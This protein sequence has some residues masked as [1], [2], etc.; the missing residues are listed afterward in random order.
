MERLVLLAAVATFLAAGCARLGVVKGGQATAEAATGGTAAQVSADGCR[1]EPFTVPSPAMK[2]E[3]RALVLLPPA[4]D[5]EPARRF[6]V[7]YAMHGAGAPYATWSEMSPLRR[8]L[9]QM[10]MIVCCF[11]GDRASMYVD[12]TVNPQSQFTTFFFD[13]LVPFIESHYRTNGVRGAT[14]FSMGGYGA[15]H[16]MLTRPE[17]FASVSSLSGAFW[18]DLAAQRGGHMKDLLGDYDQNAEAYRKCDIYGRL[19]DCVA[20]EVSLPP[21]LIHCGTEDGLVEENRK[22]ERFL[23]EQNALIRKRLEPRVSNVADESKRPRALD[24]LMLQE[25]LR[26]TYVESPGAHNWPFWRDASLGVAEFHWRS[27]QRRSP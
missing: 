16:Y 4:Y 19:K 12:S 5:A 14:G 24:E 8:A 23:I 27:F 3:I 9:A 6:P 21:M 20:R 25:G 17:M 22:F 11:D 15:F 18:G 26:F 1:V 2:R 7:L 10:P 13:E